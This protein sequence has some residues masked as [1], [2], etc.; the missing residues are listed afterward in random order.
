MGQY[1]HSRVDRDIDAFYILRMRENRQ[2]VSMGLVN[3]G[4]SNSQG[5]DGN[6]PLGLSRAGKQFNSIRTLGGVVA[7]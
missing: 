4:L 6:L 7:H 3:R 1:V 2:V 5:Q